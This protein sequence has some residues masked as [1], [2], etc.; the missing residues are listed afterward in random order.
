MS[1]GTFHVRA[2]SIEK[3]PFEQ[4]Y[5][6]FCDFDL[7]ISYFCDYDLRIYYFVIV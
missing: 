2:H 7:G 4:F 6:Y 1:E 5:A 3:F